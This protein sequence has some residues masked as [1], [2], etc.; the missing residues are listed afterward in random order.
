M[1]KI[2]RPES[3]SLAESNQKTL[4]VGIY[5]FPGWFSAWE[6][7]SVKIGRQ[8]RLLG[9]WARHVT[10]LPPPIEWLDW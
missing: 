7:D 4:K 9:L 1:L 10:G 5:S 8:V 3:E 2:G 6:R